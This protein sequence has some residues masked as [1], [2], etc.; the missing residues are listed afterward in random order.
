MSSGN[1]LDG[2]VIIVTGAARGIG[3]ALALYM[4]CR[5]ARVV[6]NDID[7]DI[8][9]ALAAEISG[10]GGEIL[11]LAGSVSDWSFAEEL[12]ARAVERFGALDGLINN[13]GLHYQALPWEEDPHSARRLLEV[14]V[15]GALYCGMQALKVFV[16]QRHGSLI[17]VTSGAHLGVA[18]QSTYAASKGAIASLTYSWALDALPYGVRVNAVA[19]L[20]HTRMT[21]SLAAYQADSGK[22]ADN[23]QGGGIRV[24]EPED[25]AP[26][27]GYLLADCSA[28]LS[29]QILRF[30]GSEL[31]LIDHPLVGASRHSREHWEID[32]VRSVLEGQMLDTLSPVGLGRMVI[33]WPPGAK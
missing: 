6:A 8:L 23:G 7:P 11:P 12:I 16:A 3:R 17:N 10:E 14:N 21:D 33:P 27:F 28:Q 31:S 25:L 18:G 9:D 5:G 1:E 29:G 19:P 13:A 22:P 20:A 4:G 26:L 2:K 30:N 32:D 24:R 15:L